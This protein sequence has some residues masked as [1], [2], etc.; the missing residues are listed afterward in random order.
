MKKTSILDVHFSHLSDGWLTPPST[1]SEWNKE[2]NFNCDP[3]ANPDFL[4]PGIEI[5]FSVRDNGLI[6]AWPGPSFV[7]PAYSQLAKWIAKSKQES[8]KAPVVMLIPAR[9]DTVAFHRYIW[10]QSN[11]RPQQN[12]Q[13]RL[14]K[15][16][17][18]FDFPITPQM[19]EAVLHFAQSK[20]APNSALDIRA[21]AKNSNLPK[22]VVQEILAGKALA[23]CSAP[24]PSMLVIFGDGA[25]GMG[26]RHP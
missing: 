9:T 13:V 24:F 17:L 2:F 21:I 10:D 11:H 3:C 14:L 18:K 16:R 20:D 26:G 25:N 15:G 23:K 19:R 4:L 6:Q 5:H 1:F 12:V 22:V 8:G 7:N